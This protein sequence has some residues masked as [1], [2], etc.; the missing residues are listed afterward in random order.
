MASPCE[1]LI[2]N[3]NHESALEISHLAQVEALR[4]QDKY[5][6]F[7]NDSVIYKINHAHNQKTNI[8]HETYKLF[9]Y[10]DMC[11]NLSNGL[12]DVTSGG[13]KKLWDFKNIK[14]L[15][16]ESDIKSQLK[17]IGWNK[18]KL[19]KHFI[20]LPKNMEI[21]LGGIGKEYA[22]DSTV[23]ILQKHFPQTPVLV[24]FGGDLSTC[25]K[26]SLPWN[27]GIEG[28]KNKVIKITQGA[29]ATSGKTKQFFIHDN[30]RY[31]HIINPKTGFPIRDAPLSVTVLASNTTQAGMLAT[32]AQ[33][34]GSRAK[35]FL[36]SQNVK[37]WCL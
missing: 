35:K 22:V 1:I 33:L 13:L 20:Q 11:H 8:D 10:A 26:P 14:V 25:N 29:L 4:I 36:S 30:K 24:N 15:P 27:I 3:A 37:F 12:F 32:F 31:S 19:S 23:G 9:Q 17:Y 5:S 7:Q 34:Q 21:D 28:Y 6:L 18:V 2:Q 16:K